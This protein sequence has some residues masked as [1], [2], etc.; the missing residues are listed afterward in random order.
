MKYSANDF[1]DDVLRVARH[2]GHRIETLRGSDIPQIDFGIKK[3][4]AHHIRALFPAVLADDAD[5][6]SMIKDVAPGR[7]C[8]HRPFREIVSQI[9]RERPNVYSEALIDSVR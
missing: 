5:I 7:P 1:V 4:H 2:Q 6:N 9:R 8:A 3:L